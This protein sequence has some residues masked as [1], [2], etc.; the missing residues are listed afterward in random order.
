MDEG[1]NR[2]RGGRT[3]GGGKKR[4]C[5]EMEG[6]GREKRERVWCKPW[7]LLDGWM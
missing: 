2:E 7:V 1:Q 4:R 6:E 5:M 3:E